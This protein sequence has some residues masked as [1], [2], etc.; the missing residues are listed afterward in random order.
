MVRPNRRELLAGASALALGAARGG[1]AAPAGRRPPNV[2]FLIADQHRADVA[3]FAGH[4]AAATPNLDSLAASGAVLSRLYCHNPLCVP[5]RQSLITGLPSHAHGWFGNVAG[6]PSDLVTLA[7]HWKR[8]GY[9][10]AMLGKAHMATHDFE[11][12]VEKAALYRAWKA[13]HPHGGQAGDKALRERAGRLPEGLLELNPYLDAPD[14][15][16]F[17]MEPALGRE[18]ERFLAARDPERPFFLW[19]SLVQPHPPRF[20]PAEWLARTR[21]LE[22]P[23]PAVPD[24]RELAAMPGYARDMRRLTGVAQ[25]APQEVANVVR[26]YWAAVGWADHWVGEILKSVERAGLA[27]ETIVVYTSDHGEMLGEHGLYGKFTLYEG[28]CRVPGV[29]VLPDRSLAG[30]RVTRVAQHLDLVA[31]LFELAGLPQPE[32]LAGT[33]LAELCSGWKGGA[34]AEEALVELY[35][36]A[37]SH[38]SVPREA[39]AACLVTPQ[40]KYAFHAPGEESLVDLA[41]DPGERVNLAAQPERAALLAELRARVRELVPEKVYVMRRVDDERR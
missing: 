37:E 9:Q 19:A 34:R 26:A 13:D 27:Q 22:V 38:V 29:V 12:C 30:R 32:R 7:D 6:F 2:L 41:E 11:V 25:L 16:E 1:R 20:P 28:A 39:L 23:L 15:G 35:Y 33:P 14:A 21:R 24:E 18:V 40:W 5:A 8:H 17:Q 31:S 36:R 10:T 4:A 3:G